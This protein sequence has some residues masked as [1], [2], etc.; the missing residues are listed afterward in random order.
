MMLEKRCGDLVETWSTVLC[1]N[2][3]FRSTHFQASPSMSELQTLKHLTNTR[4]DRLRLRVECSQEKLGLVVVWDLRKNNSRVLPKNYRWTQHQVY[5]GCTHSHPG[6][7]FH[8]SCRKTCSCLRFHRNPAGGWTVQDAHRG[9]TGFSDIWVWA[10]FIQIME[11]SV[12][13]SS[14]ASSIFD[15]R[16]CAHGITGLPR[17][18]G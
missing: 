6:I 18:S 12:S 10:F 1:A 17:I 5:G 2:S 15:L 9:M 4:D 7:I 3:Q 16:V 13:S 11:H 14:R 8:R